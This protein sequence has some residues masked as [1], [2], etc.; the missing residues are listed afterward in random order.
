MNLVAKKMRAS[1][2]HSIV[3]D[4]RKHAWILYFCVL[5]II[6]YRHFYRQKTNAFAGAGDGLGLRG[7]YSSPSIVNERCEP[8][9]LKIWIILRSRRPTTSTAPKQS[10]ATL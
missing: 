10:L 1:I 7:G 2:P 3:S 5:I 8:T 6:I 9:N 4:G